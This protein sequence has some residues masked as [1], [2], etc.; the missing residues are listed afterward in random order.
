MSVQIKLDPFTHKKLKHRFK[1]LGRIYPD[2]TFR[3]IIKILFDMKRL[4]Q[5]KIKRDGHIVTARLRNSLFV[6]T[7]SNKLSNRANNKPIYSDKDGN[8]FKSKINVRLKQ[9]QGAFG[10]N[11]IYAGKIEK[12]DSFIEWAIKNVDVN[13]RLREITDNARKKIK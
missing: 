10:T 2:E 13:K 7:L 5:Q 3:A 6:Q 11:V 1:V 12:L 8:V 9:L 4:A